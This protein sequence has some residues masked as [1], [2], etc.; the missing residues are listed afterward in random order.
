VFGAESSKMA[1]SKDDPL[2]RECE[3]L[4]RGR[5]P[6]R[7]HRQAVKDAVRN[8]VGNQVRAALRDES[9]PRVCSGSLTIQLPDFCRVVFLPNLH[10][11]AHHVPS[12]NQIR[13]CLADLRPHLVVFTGDTLELFTRWRYGLAEMGVESTAPGARSVIA[14]ILEVS[15]AVHAFIVSGL[16]A[17]RVSAFASTLPADLPASIV[18]PQSSVDDSFD[19]GALV[20]AD[21]F[22]R[23]DVD[24]IR[25]LERYSMGSMVYAGSHMLMSTSV[26]REVYAYRLG[27]LADRSQRLLARPRDVERGF[28]GFD[29]G[30]VIGGRIHLHPIPIKPISKKTAGFVL[31]GKRYSF[32]ADE[33]S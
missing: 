16:S 9:D 14:D 29:E 7:A 22:V 10:L 11:P 6:G 2:R 5:K 20:L 13:I 31:H 32:P 18:C 19:D 15:A 21:T 26:L 17:A 3:P 27:H 24:P 23:H 28:L 1:K 30:A 8:A 25:W 4:D 12:F 33:L